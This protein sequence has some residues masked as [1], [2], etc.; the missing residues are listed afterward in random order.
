MWINTPNNTSGFNI[1]SGKDSI[2]SFDIFDT[3]TGLK[4]TLRNVELVEHTVSVEPMDIASDPNVSYFAN[5]QI[6]RNLKVKVRYAPSQTIQSILKSPLNRIE[7]VVLVEENGDEVEDK[8]EFVRRKMRGEID[9][10][11]VTGSGIIHTF[12]VESDGSI[13]LDIVILGNLSYK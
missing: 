5:A 3:S 1:S 4:A 8:A 10:V 11:H 13:E 12:C 6:H 7:F 9:K 2:I